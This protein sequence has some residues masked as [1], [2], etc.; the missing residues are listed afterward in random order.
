MESH[1]AELLKVDHLPPVLPW[2]PTDNRVERLAPFP[3]TKDKF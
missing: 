3:F 1:C 2:I